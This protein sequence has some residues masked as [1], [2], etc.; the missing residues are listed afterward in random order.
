MRGLAAALALACSG[1]FAQAPDR[2]TPAALAELGLAALRQE[3]GPANRVVS[4]LATAAALG[5]LHAG[6]NGTAETE[7]EV[8]LGGPGAAPLRTRL[9]ALLKSLAAPA[10]ATPPFVMAARAWIDESA[11][12]AVP[13]AYTRRLAQRY[14]ADAARIDFGASEDARSRINAWTAEHSAGRI[15]E[16]LPP[17]S[18]TPATRLTLS[19]ALHFRSAWERPFDPAATEALPFQAAGA[20][21]K[22]VPTMVD[23][24]GVL[25]AELEDRTQLFALPFAGEAWVLLLALPAEGRSVTNLARGITGAAVAGWLPRLKP[26]KCRLALPRFEIAPQPV[27]VKPLLEGLGVKTAFTPTADLRPMLGRASHGVNLA[28]L[29]AAAGLR[30]DETGGEAVAAAAAT[31][32]AKTF[33]LPVPDCALQRPFLFAVLHRETATPLVMGRLGDPSP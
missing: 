1:V 21:A 31:L 22:P 19:S 25:Q 18:L 17:G 32:Q 33:A 29:H 26:Q 24:R 16:L 14:G 3:G 28:E 6:L 8:L 15:A 10:G 27:A 2:A 5:L 11:A 4:P 7:I 12:P 23:E 9:P 13:R 20:A 30:I